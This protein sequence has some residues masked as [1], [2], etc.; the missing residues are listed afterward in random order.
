MQTNHASDYAAKPGRIYVMTASDMGWGQD[1]TQGFQQEF[2]IIVHDCGS[3]AGF[4]EIS[5]LELNKN[6]PM[7][8]A[9]EFHP[10]T[11]LSISHGG[12]IVTM[13]GGNRLSI[14]YDATLT[15]WDLK[16]PVWRGSFNFARGGTLIPL[17]ERG[18]VFAVDL[19]NGLKRDGLLKSCSEIKL[20]PGNRL[21]HNGTSGG[22]A[23]SQPST[24]VINDNP[25]NHRRGAVPMSSLEGLLPGDDLGQ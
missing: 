4:G 9:E 15:D 16:R 13:G 7:E 24:T 2:G 18:A 3:V 17:A 20:Q 25:H 21:E 11:L 1:F 23:L 10:D 14:A 12:G 5:G 19:T 8:K 6:G 22:S